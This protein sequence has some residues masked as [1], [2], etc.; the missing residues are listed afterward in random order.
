MP[1]AARAW[2]V[3]EYTMISPISAIDTSAPT[4]PASRLR[5]GRL[6]PTDRRRLLEVAAPAPS[7][8]V[9]T[10]TGAL[11]AFALCFP[12]PAA[13]AARCARSQPHSVR[14]LSA[15]RSPPLGRSLRS[16]RA[17]PRSAPRAVVA[18]LAHSRTN[19]A[20]G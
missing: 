12:L 19:L 13:R 15:S 16:L 4:K 7:G 8:L 3:D 5:H 10:L 9:A 18:A 14:S 17:D 20:P 2:R 11:R 1:P 6:I